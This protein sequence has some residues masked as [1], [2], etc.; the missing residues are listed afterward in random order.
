MGYV[1]GK[2]VGVMKSRKQAR[3]MLIYYLR[4]KV[5]H[6]TIYCENKCRRGLGR[7][8]VC[9]CIYKKTVSSAL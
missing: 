2:A 4:N 6:G 9:M 8:C 7:L 5:N 3:V 1:G